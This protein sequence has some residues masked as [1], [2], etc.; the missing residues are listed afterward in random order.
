MTTNKALLARIK[1]L[2][3]A[4]ID[5]IELVGCALGDESEEVEDLVAVLNDVPAE[6]LDKTTPQQ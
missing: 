4:L 6:G 5:A 3:V 1:A 2:E